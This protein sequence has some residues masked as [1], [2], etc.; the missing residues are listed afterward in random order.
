MPLSATE[1]NRLYGVLEGRLADRVFI[2]DDYSIADMVAYP[3]IVPYER[4]G[5]KLTDFPNLKRWLKSIRERPAT[6]GAYELA[7][8]GAR[9]SDPRS[10]CHFDVML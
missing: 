5:Q 2:A 3:W 1:T 9:H 7:K 8:C 4:Q 10:N 6:I